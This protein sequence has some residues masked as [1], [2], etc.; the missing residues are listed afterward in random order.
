MIKGSCKKKTLK[1]GDW[2]LDIKCGPKDKIEISIWLKNESTET[3]GFDGAVE[4]GAVE[5]SG[6]NWYDVSQE[7]PWKLNKP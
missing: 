3:S 5:L 4:I 1:M 6:K 7:L 2:I